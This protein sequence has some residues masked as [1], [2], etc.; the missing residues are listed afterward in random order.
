[1]AAVWPNVSNFAAVETKRF[2]SKFIADTLKAS[3][4][5]GVKEV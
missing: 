1:M 5:P 3:P 2:M 4:P